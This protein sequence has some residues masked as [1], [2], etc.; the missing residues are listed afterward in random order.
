[1]KRSWDSVAID[2]N[3]LGQ[4]QALQQLQQKAQRPPAQR[5]SPPEH[6]QPTVAPQMPQTAQTATVRPPLWRGKG[7]HKDGKDGKDGKEHRDGKG[8]HKDGKDTPL[9][10]PLP[11]GPVSFSQHGRPPPVKAISKAKMLS[12]APGQSVETPVL[13]PARVSYGAKQSDEVSAAPR[14]EQQQKQLKQ[15]QQQ[16]QQQKQQ[17]QKQRRPSPERSQMVEKWGQGRKRPGVAA[18]AQR[19]AEGLPLDEALEPLNL[20][21]FKDSLLRLGV[22]SPADLRYVTDEDFKAMRL[23]IIQRRKF[24]ELIQR[25]SCT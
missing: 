19:D 24:E 10:E 2:P 15:Q 9:R 25:Y 6:L 5:V 13:R 23:N 11:V 1:M 4:Q 18:A 7:H 3:L 20:G 22:E 8:Q 17:F 12:S 21:A 16:Q 14:A